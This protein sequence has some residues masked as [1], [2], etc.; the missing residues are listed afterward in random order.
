MGRQW[1]EHQFGGSAT[2]L[3]AALRPWPSEYMEAWDVSTLVNAPE[4]DSAECI[5]PSSCGQQRQRQLPL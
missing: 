2:A 5:Q 3:D 4:N 1:L